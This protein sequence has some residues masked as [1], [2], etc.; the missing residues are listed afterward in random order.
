MKIIM[1]KDIFS[2]T[3]G[4]RH[5]EEGDFSG[6]EFRKSILLP[7]IRNAINMNEQLSV[8]LDGTAGY[9]TSFLEESF[10]GLIRVDHLSYEDI[11]N[12][13]RIISSEEPYLIDDINNYLLEAKSEI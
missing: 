6:Q 9:G 8:N 2:Q 10:G 5:I 13:L 4:P 11:T 12:S 7:A 3:P 1:I